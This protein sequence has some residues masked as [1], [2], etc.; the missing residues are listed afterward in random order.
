MR[1]RM[2]EQGLSQS[3]LARRVGVSQAAIGA[4]VTGVTRESRKLHLIARELQTTPDYLAGETDDPAEGAPLAPTAESLAEQMDAV[5]LPEIDVTFGM[6]GGSFSEGHAE[7]R[8]VPISRAWLRTLT[9]SPA[10]DLMVA[11][12][13]GDSMMPTILDQ[14]IVIID[15]SQNTPRQQDRIWALTYGELGM[16]KRLRQL[17]G[18]AL[19]INSDNAAVSPIVAHDDEARIVGRVVGIVRRV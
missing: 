15:R 5:L 2:A 3:E 18:G 13:D 9:N 1:E 12:G 6:G 14:D 16:I 8:L 19:Q 17:P 10:T 11:R 4:L 7:V